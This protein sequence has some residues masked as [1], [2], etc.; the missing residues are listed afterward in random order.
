MKISGPN[1]VKNS[2]VGESN[3]NVKV[4]M[5]SRFQILDGV[6]EEE[7]DEM[8]L[9]QDRLVDKKKEV[10]VD[11]TNGVSSGGG[12]SGVAKGKSISL[13]MYKASSMKVDK[14]GCS[15][16]GARSKKNLLARETSSRESVEDGQVEADAVKEKNNIAGPVQKID[17]LDA[18]FENV[19][20]K[21]REAMVVS[22]D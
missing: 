7:L 19:A 4:N 9:S 14:G 6:N 12:K 20:P 22:L 16:S 17:V 21:L 18:S 11:V 5:G 1:L 3:S 13:R 8:V 2:G 10:L 15:S